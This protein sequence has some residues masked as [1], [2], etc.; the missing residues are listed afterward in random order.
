MLA[1]HEPV[2]IFWQ[3]G[4]EKYWS[5]FVTDFS[6][7]TV[8]DNWWDYPWGANWCARREALLRA[9]GFRCSYG[10]KGNDFSGGEEIIAA[11]VINKLGYTIA[12][13]P[14]AKV[15]HNIEVSR[16]SLGHMKNTI[17]AGLFT[18]YQA[19]LDLYIPLEGSIWKT[20]NQINKSLSKGLSTFQ[21]SR[22]WN[23][24]RMIETYYY[25]SARGRLLFRQIADNI[26]R[27][28]KPITRT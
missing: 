24:A 22:T 13:L 17:K 16:F 3:E 15:I 4:W 20:F 1:L 21:L 5:H 14:Q 12:V 7:Y 2:P 19:Q 27:L 23:K 8:V 10:R 25:I 6:T 11:S 18:E 26:K 28:R 9:G